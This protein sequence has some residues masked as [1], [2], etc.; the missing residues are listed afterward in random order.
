M[1]NLD[2]VHLVEQGTD[3]G[4]DGWGSEDSNTYSALKNPHSGKK[5]GMYTTLF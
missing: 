5:K 4:V 2:S 1:D 3:D